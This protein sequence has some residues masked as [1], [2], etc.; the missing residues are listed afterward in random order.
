MEGAMESN[1][2][3]PDGAL[4]RLD[5]RGSAALREV[6]TRELAI[7]LRDRLRASDL[8]LER[9]DLADQLGLLGI[10]IEV[11]VESPWNR[12]SRTRVSSIA[13]LLAPAIEDG[14]LQMEGATV[15]D[16]GC[17][18]I[19]PLGPSLMH[20]LC[21][22]KL[23]V[24]VDLDPPQDPVAA[25]RAMC[26][27]A[28]A[29][30]AAPEHVMPWGKRSR[31]QVLRALDGFDLAKLWIGDASGLDTRR[32]QLHHVSAA[33]LPF[34]DNSVDA[35]TSVSFLEHVDD[36]DAVL[37]EMARVLRPG[38]YVVHSIDGLDHG[39]YGDDAIGPLD[40]LCEPAEPRQ[41]RGC[42]R[43]RPVEFVARFERAGF[44]VLAF[45]EHAR[46]EVDASLR[47]RF[48]KPWRDMSARE[49][50]VTQGA[51]RVRKKATK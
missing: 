47:A 5:D 4:R 24:G 39:S 42:N 48:A 41:V 46:I 21:G 51:I 17:G 19:H 10:E 45:E 15:V 36:V 44:E 8:K 1:P 32:L 27:L 43:L 33:S 30:L 3:L 18:S 26:R 13:G 14:S 38:G 29:T 40:F 49:L 20:V 31:E 34:A 6:A 16:L 2:P 50:E 11:R 12:F 22:A 7:A 35:C 25:S 23:A 9:G 37:A 28:L